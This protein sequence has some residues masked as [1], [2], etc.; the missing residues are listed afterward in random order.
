VTAT[1]KDGVNVLDVEKRLTR[2]ADRYAATLAPD[3]ELKLAFDQSDD[4]RRKLALLARDFALALALVLLTLLP[5]GPRASAVVM[6]SVPLSL[7]VGVL[8]MNVLGYTLNQLVI[9]GFVVALGILVDDSIVVVE[10]IARHLRMGYSRTE[11]ALAGTQQIAVAVV[12]CTAVLVFAFLPLTALP[13]GAGK[14]VRGL[15][16]AVIATV[17]ASLF[18]SLTIIPFL[19]SR[20]LPR[21]EAA[22]GNR[23]LRAVNGGIQR[24][25]APMLHW[26][27]ERPRTA[28][29]AAWCFAKEPH[30]FPVRDLVEEHADVVVPVA[31]K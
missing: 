18:I 10:N 27:L 6:V 16:I 31:N 3:V 30:A 23:F 11:A 12:G 25:Y 13:G 19:A 21:E 5:L 17:V 28:L 15:P 1:Q 4:V 8:V 26:A 7:A 20:L 14:F 24:F 29:A 9:T 22:E 2:A